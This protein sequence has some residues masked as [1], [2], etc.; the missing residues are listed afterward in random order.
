[1]S[2]SRTAVVALTC[3]LTM[4]GISALAVE[5]TTTGKQALRQ[6]SR[7]PVAKLADDSDSLRQGTVTALSAKGD[8]VEIRGRWHTILPGRTTFFRLGQPVA[9]D[10]LKKGQALKF[11]LAGGSADRNALGVVYVP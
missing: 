1:M 5:V 11:T 9:A 4:S 2:Q 7:A 3:L 10:T 8:Q 6:A